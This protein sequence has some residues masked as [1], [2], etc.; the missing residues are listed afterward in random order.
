MDHLVLI[1]GHHLMYRA[2][3][4]IPRTLRTRSG[5]QVNAVFGM[6]SMLLSILK[7]E[8]PDAL[9]LCFDVGEETFR[10]QEHEA[11]K[12][13]RAETPEDFYRQIPLI[14][15][16]IDAFGFSHVADPKF[17]ADDFLCTYAWAGERAGMRVSVVT[18]DRDALQLASDAVRIIIPHKGYQEAETL[19]PLEVEK[20]YGVRPDQIAA[21]KGLAGDSSDN[22]SGVRGI[23]PKGAA[24]LLQQFGTL[25]ALY[26]HL[27]E[28]SPSLRQKLEDGRA[29]AFF[30]QHMAQL[31]RDIPLP[32]PLDAL[33]LRALPS[34]RILSTFQRFEFTLLLRRFRELLA[35]PYGSRVFQEL[36]L[37]S[38]QQLSLF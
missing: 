29:Q 9:L 36:P 10:H 11:Y 14:L 19:G 16:M 2:Y 12:E 25:E 13:G 23:G 24:K 4:A 21:W 35:T 1:D 26:A 7:Q 27:S 18:G 6:A 22:F 31:V 34:E 20:K 37:S 8:T 28:V 33:S 30:C 15:E 5:L 3:W 32:L 38:E 17:E